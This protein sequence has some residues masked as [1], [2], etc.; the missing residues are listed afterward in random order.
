[1]WGSTF[2]ADGDRKTIAVCNCHDLGAFATL[3]LAD[4]SAPLFAG[5]KLPSMKASSRSNIPPTRRCSASASST[6]RITPERNPLLETTMTGLVRWVA[7]WQVRPRCP[8]TQD[9]KNAVED[10]TPRFPW[11]SAT[12][13]TTNCF[14]D[15]RVQHCPL[16]VSEV[17]RGGHLFK[18]P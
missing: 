14:G 15:Q 12:V 18:T 5:A 1:M 6:P 7:F 10:I 9:V 8:C 4:P 17:A 13:L 16:G 3:C 2:R 11:S